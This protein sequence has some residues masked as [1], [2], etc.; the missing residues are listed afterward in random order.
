MSLSDKKCQPCESGVGLLNE[1]DEERYAQQVPSWSLERED[2]HR[3][4]RV[5][6]L[7]NFV[8][9]IQFVN[10]VAEIAED[11]GHHPNLHIFGWNKVR[12]E[13]NTHSA[14]GLTEN[15]FILAA[16]IDGLQPE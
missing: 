13:I 15:D 8:E 10:Q 6:K 2:E 9:A 5:Y 3:I 14:G 16:K 12:I 4:E 7:K 11:E 1:A